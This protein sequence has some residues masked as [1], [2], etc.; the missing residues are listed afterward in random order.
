MAPTNYLR[1]PAQFIGQRFAVHG[2][3]TIR[4]MGPGN[5]SST[6]GFSFHRTPGSSDTLFNVFEPLLFENVDL[7]INQSKARRLAQEGTPLQ[8]VQ[9]PEKVP[10]R[11]DADCSRIPRAVCGPRSKKCATVRRVKGPMGYLV[12]N[13]YPDR[14]PLGSEAIPV[15][16]YPGEMRNGKFVP[17][18]FYDVRCPEKD[19]SLCP[20]LTKARLM[21][22]VPNTVAQ[23]RQGEQPFAT[24][25]LAG[26]HS[27]ARRRIR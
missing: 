4:S 23:G 6:P 12:G 1:L 8:V 15:A 22:F 20:A 3:S 24:Q 26:L 18:K 11:T 5:A 14:G 19:K 7:V 13:V 21:R 25:M 10:C 2:N 17:G 9:W 16:L 27:S